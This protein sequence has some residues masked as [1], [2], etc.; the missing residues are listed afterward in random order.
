M[1]LQDTAS[2]NEQKGDVHWVVVR[3]FRL[4]RPDDGIE[5]LRNTLHKIEQKKRR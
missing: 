5:L 3:A 2:G 4:K 1:Y